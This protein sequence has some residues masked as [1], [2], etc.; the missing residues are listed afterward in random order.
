MGEVMGEAGPLP[1]LTPPLVLTTL[2]E[3]G[4]GVNP[5]GEDPT[6][7]GV[8]EGAMLVSIERSLP[9]TNETSTPPSVEVSLA[10]PE[11]A[12]LAGVVGNELCMIALPSSDWASKSSG[13]RRSFSI[14]DFRLDN[15]NRLAGCFWE[16]KECYVRILE[17]VN[18][19][20]DPLR[21]RSESPIR[22][23]VRPRN[24]FQFRNF[25]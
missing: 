17:T 23:L 8:G 20:L 5:P 15:G 25:F 9:L 1:G 7:V 24:R 11:A 21:T 12:S 4:E 6:A 16:V 19:L 13:G 3:M 18:G 2:G 10:V 14:S 22:Q